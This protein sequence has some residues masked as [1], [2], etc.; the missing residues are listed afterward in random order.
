[1]RDQQDKSTDNKAEE[2]SICPFARA[3]RERTEQT[4]IEWTQAATDMLDSVPVGFC[5]D[6]THKAATSIAT[7]KNVNR[8]DETFVQSVLDTFTQGSG[9]INETL[10]WDDDARQRLIKAP[11]MVR[12]MLVKEIETWVKEQ[13][14]THV[15][16][17]AVEVAKQRWETE[18]IFHMGAD[19]PRNT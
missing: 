2:I 6:M 15:D 14:N 8:I 19:D 9:D 10:P 13:G 12:G 1:M 7:Q 3:A 11:D 16:H 5:R 4:E 17:A 18:G